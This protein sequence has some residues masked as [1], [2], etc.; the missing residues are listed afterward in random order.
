MVKEREMKIEKVSD[1][2][3]SRSSK[4]RVKKTLPSVYN[5][6]AVF[7][8]RYIAAS[9]SFTFLFETVSCA[10]QICDQTEVWSSQA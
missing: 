9:P 1:F 7:F 8:D 5:T 2:M 10:T 4:L 3:I 6:F